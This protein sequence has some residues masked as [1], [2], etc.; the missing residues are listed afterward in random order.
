M[1]FS[2]AQQREFTTE[3][4]NRVTRYQ[5]EILEATREFTDGWEA[6]AGESVDLRMAIAAMESALQRLATNDATAAA[7]DEQVALGS[8]IR[9]RQNIRQKLSES[10]SSSSACRTFDRQQQQKLRKPEQ[11][12]KDQNQQLTELRQNMDSLAQE[13][14]QWSEEVKSG[15]KPQLDSESSPTDPMPTESAS[16]SSPSSSSKPS[17]TAQELAQKQ[18]EL[19]EAWEKLRE[20]VA[21]LPDASTPVQES[22]A[23]IAA[24]MQ[25]G[26]EAQQQG[27]AE[28]AAESGES[29]A[30]LLERLADHLATSQSSD[31]LER[32]SQAQQLAAG[33]AQSER[34]LADQIAAKTGQPAAVAG[35]SAVGVNSDAQA[36]AA[37]ALAALP[38][39]ERAHLAGRQQGLAAQGA[40]LAEQLERLRGEALATDPRAADALQRVQQTHAPQDIADEMA[41][42]GSEISQGHRRA[43]QTLADAEQRL[44]ELAGDLQA[45][46]TELGQPRL[47]ELIALEQELARTIEQ[48]QNP[49]TAATLADAELGELERKLAA[50]AAGD[51]RMEQALNGTPSE[52]PTGQPSGSSPGEQGEPQSAT[53]GEPPGT[54]PANSSSNSTNNSA[55]QSGT[56]F[57]PQGEQPVR[58]GFYSRSNWMTPTRLRQANEVVQRQ[59]QEIILAGAQMDGDAAV[60]PQYA[61]LIEEYYR[62]L[63]DDLR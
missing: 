63:S 38:A 51:R 50:L 19:Q 30:E 23:E 35:N 58:P 13:Q 56:A 25:R 6:L 62:R 59:I 34:R 7:D 8:L 9:A 2:A 1:T 40:L 20:Q 52:S 41:L 16:S 43:L 33:L 17:P 22:A 48:L 5:T 21:A 11:P 31:V 14:R 55:T 3:I 47:E 54:S 36:E 37:E 61:P 10:S 29:A 46:R 32:L 60:P 4:G 24:N 44:G 27:D 18:Q 45:A 28:Q 26:L 49:A 12:K 39:A 53:A 42:A 15:S 57:S